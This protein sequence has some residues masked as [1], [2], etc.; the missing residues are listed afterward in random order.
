M[1]LWKN[2]GP[3]RD[4]WFEECWHKSESDDDDEKF[5][6]LGD[7]EHLCIVRLRGETQYWIT[8]TDEYPPFDDIGPFENKEVAEV[9]LKLM[10]A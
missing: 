1:V 8:G 5:W 9:Y 2:E 10:G 7:G 6:H 3:H 4:G